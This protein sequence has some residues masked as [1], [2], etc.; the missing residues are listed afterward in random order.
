MANEESRPTRAQSLIT[1]FKLEPRKVNT[2]L[3]MYNKALYLYGNV[4]LTVVIFDVLM[5]CDDWSNTESL[6]LFV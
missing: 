5:I 1:Q 4:F 3:R 6:T 2:A